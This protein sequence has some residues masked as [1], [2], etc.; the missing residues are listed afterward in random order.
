MVT[1]YHSS[2]FRFKDDGFLFTDTPR[3][4]EGTEDPS[5]EYASQNSTAESTIH[6][7]N[8]Q[9]VP[10]DG[11]EK[12][13]EHDI[14]E[15][16]QET[17]VQGAFL[18][19]EQAKQDKDVKENGFE[20]FTEKPSDD[21]L[22]LNSDRGENVLHNEIDVML[23]GAAAPSSDIPESQTKSIEETHLELA[24]P[25]LNI[26]DPQ[27][28]RSY[29]SEPYLPGSDP[30]ESSSDRPG[31]IYRDIYVTHRPKWDGRG[32]LD[33][34]P[35]VED[36][37]SETESQEMTIGDLEDLVLTENIQ[38]KLS[39]SWL[40]CTTPGY[41]NKLVASEKHVWCVDSKERVYFSLA[42]KLACSWNKLKG[43]HARQ[44]AVSPSGNIVWIVKGR[45][46]GAYASNPIM[47]KS[48]VGSRWHFIC[49]DV[50]F[51]CLDETTAWIIKENGEVLVHN[52]ITREKPYTR[53]KLVESNFD[54]REIV[55]NRG[56][57]WALTSEHKVVYRSEVSTIKMY[58]KRWKMMEDS[59]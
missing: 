26:S 9:R 1:T 18:S 25:K 14:A 22:A 43:I 48:K 45:H 19:E 23:I 8:M 32:P 56:V 52:G 20:L 35:E 29:D 50:S 58:G 55:A 31:S 3:E 51:I 57:V 59:R 54:I 36:T 21:Q 28:L 11:A 2:D 53:P 40:H 42:S 13:S 27:P 7:T 34:M 10:A 17:I 49:Q 39:S 15:S 41:I 24:V 30:Q 4:G 38:Q 37:D 44:I 5:A 33:E 6:Q 47:P 46:N 12:T 16:M